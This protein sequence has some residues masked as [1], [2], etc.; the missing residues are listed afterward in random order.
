M[1]TY[2]LIDLWLKGNYLTGVV[3]VSW[4]HID[5]LYISGSYSIDKSFQDFPANSDGYSLDQDQS[6][7]SEL[8]SIRFNNY[9]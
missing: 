8:N 7:I 3:P 6:C 1:A 4:G 5:Q 2:A 9:K